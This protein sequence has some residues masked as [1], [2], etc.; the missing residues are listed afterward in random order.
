MVNWGK[1]TTLADAFNQI[2]IK[3]NGEGESGVDE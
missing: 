2:F 1:I 3:R